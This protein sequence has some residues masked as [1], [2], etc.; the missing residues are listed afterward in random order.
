MAKKIL[1]Q[2]L[3]KSDEM[4][5]TGLLSLLP[6]Q[7]RGEWTITDKGVGDITIIDIDDPGGIDLAKKLEHNGQLIFSLTV[8]KDDDIPGIRLRKPL[9]SKDILNCF[10]QIAHFSSGKEAPGKA[11]SAAAAVTAQ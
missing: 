6:S 4:A 1:L 8:R 10:E 2:G 11:A 3:R 9:R 7:H 5:L